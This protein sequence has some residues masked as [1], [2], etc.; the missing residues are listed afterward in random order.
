[1]IKKDGVPL[2]GIVGL[3]IVITTPLLILLLTFICVDVA[4]TDSL[5][6]II[7]AKL[8]FEYGCGALALLFLYGTYLLFT[9]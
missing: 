2:K 4:M 3:G 9:H 8:L 1:M 6:A 5:S 7:S